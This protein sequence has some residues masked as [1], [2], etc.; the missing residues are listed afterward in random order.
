MLISS[1]NYADYP[2]LIT[3]HSGE[4]ENRHLRREYLAVL[5]TNHRTPC[6]FNLYHGDTAQARFLH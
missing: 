5:E 2:F 4:R 3:L 6:F 1:A